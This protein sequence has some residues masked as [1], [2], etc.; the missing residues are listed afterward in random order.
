MEKTSAVG[1]RARR[2][3]YANMGHVDI[4]VE[5]SALHRRNSQVVRHIA[6]FIRDPN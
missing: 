2:E 5:F 6:E 3:V 1:G 4:I